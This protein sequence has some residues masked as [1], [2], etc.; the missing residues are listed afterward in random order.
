[1]LLE[2]VKS[3]FGL[4][5]ELCVCFIP[6]RPEA[7]ERGGEAGGSGRAAGGGQHLH[8]PRDRPAG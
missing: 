6:G 5:S 4:I 8:L 2:S 3:M 7:G 1:M